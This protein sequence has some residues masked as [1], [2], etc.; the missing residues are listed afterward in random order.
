MIELMIVVAIIG[1]LAAVAIPV[2]SR[3]TN[4]AKRVE[5]ETQLTNLAAGEEDYFSNYRHYTD[6]QEKIEKLFGTALTGKN[7]RIEV[8]LESNKSSF[9]AKAY[10]CYN[11]SGTSCGSGNYNVKCEISNTNRE[12]VCKDKQ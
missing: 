10:V 8:A 1:V 9:T 7:Y 6:S 3:Y 12:P 5:A 4:R 11:V 2:Y